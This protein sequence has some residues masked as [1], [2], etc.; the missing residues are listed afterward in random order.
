MQEAATVAFAVMLTEVAGHVTVRPAAG[1]TVD[2]RVMLPAKSNLLVR[3]TEMLAPE[4]PVL[5]L[6]ELAE[7]VKSPTWTTAKAE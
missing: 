7:M 6:T 5:K 4:A 3:E 2:V 1:A